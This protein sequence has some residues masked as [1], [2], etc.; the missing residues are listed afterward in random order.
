MSSSART[1]DSVPSAASSSVPR[2]GAAVSERNADLAVADRN[3]GDLGAGCDLAR[4]PSIRSARR[5]G[6]AADCPRRCARDPARRCPRCRS[7]APRYPRDHLPPKRASADRRKL[8]SRP[9]PA[10]FRV[11]RR[12]VVRRVTAH[13]RADPR[14]P[15]LHRGRPRASSIRTRTRS[16]Q[17]PVRKQSSDRQTDY[18]GARDQHRDGFAERRSSLRKV[19]AAR[20]TRQPPGPPHRLTREQRL[21]AGQQVECHEPQAA[22]HGQTRAQARRTTESGRA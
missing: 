9:R 22:A 12:L 6:C 19:Q 7:A 11:A 4:Q 10:R 8:A 13:T 15:H 17:R 1:I 20:K 16:A 2:R 18:A 3:R 5:A 21:G 14:S